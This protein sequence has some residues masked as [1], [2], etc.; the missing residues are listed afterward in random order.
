MTDFCFKKGI[1]LPRLRPAAATEIR[2]QLGKQ[3]PEI[4]RFD[5]ADFDSRLE[6]LVDYPPTGGTPVDKGSLLELRNHFCVHPPEE[7]RSASGADKS[8]F[9]L[10][11]GRILW[12]ASEKNPGEFGNAAVWDFLTLVLLPDFATWRFDAQQASRFSG[13]SRRHVFQRLWKRW[14]VFGESRVL[15]NSLTEDDYVALM[16]RRLT[17]ERRMVAQRVAETISNLHTGEEPVV[18][19]EYTRKFMR[20]LRQLSGVVAIDDGDP[21]A[22]DDVIQYVDG[23]VRKELRGVKRGEQAT[24]R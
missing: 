18:E 5:L 8:E 1:L 6:H 14:A 2:N 15:S 24:T 11:A 19:R 12:H 9:D 22:I 16:E 23:I 10:R 3:A 13:G 7:R 17:S 20:H 4:W 21:S